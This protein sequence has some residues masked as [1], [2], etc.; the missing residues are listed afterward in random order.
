MN[1]NSLFLPSSA[2]GRS[3]PWP[4][5]ET[6]LKGFAYPFGVTYDPVNGYVYV[7]N[8]GSS[9]VSILDPAN[10]QVVASVSLGIGVEGMVCDALGNVYVGSGSAVAVI[11]GKTN[12]VISTVSIPNAVGNPVAYDSQNRLVYS[13]SSVNSSLYAINETAIVS[14]LTLPGLVATQGAYDGGTGQVWITSI[15]QYNHPENISRINGTT[16]AIVGSAQPTEPPSQMVYVPVTRAMYGA[17]E[18]GNLT[19]I[20]DLTNQ[21]LAVLHLN[22]NRNGARLGGEAYD[23]QNGNLYVT[24]RLSGTGPGDQVYVVNATTNT[25]VQNL[26]VWSSP[27]GIAYDDHT[28]ELFVANSESGSV[29]VINLTATY[30]LD[31]TET[32]LPTGTPWSVS[33]SGAVHMGTG[34]DLGFSEPNGTYDF[35]VPPTRGYFPRLTQVVVTVDGNDVGVVVQFLPPSSSVRFEESGLPT[36]TEWSAQLGGLLRSSTLSSLT[37]NES[38]GT[39]AFYVPGVAGF[40]AHPSSGGLSVLGLPVVQTI[41]FTSSPSASAPS[42]FGM[43]PI[44]SAL[45]VGSILLSV[46]MLATMF[47]LG[48][49]RRRRRSSRD[50]HRTLPPPSPT[51]VFPPTYAAG[52]ASMVELST[53]NAREA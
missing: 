49:V 28:N 26:T 6:T 32:G 46:L 30:H 8:F 24:D 21:D 1:P 23:P 19:V 42:L 3:G 5:N 27:I 22:D 51:F 36:A 20:S 10:N 33:A 52:P 50:A 37:F 53:E 38:N 48:A 47:L 16:N 11:S 45:I 34:P 41:N 7:S 2:Q 12:S 13:P 15:V 25:L 17:G 18:W 14:T 31:F 43:P 44:A 29:S 40:L 9:S 39:Y 4:L 35:S